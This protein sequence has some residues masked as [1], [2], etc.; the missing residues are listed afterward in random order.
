[1]TQ[2]VL[3]LGASGKI[4]H[5]AIHAFKTAGWDVRTYDRAAGNMTQQAKG[6]DVIINGLNPPAYQNWKTEIPR[7]TRDV[8]AAAKASNATVIIPGNIYNFGAC[9]GTLDETTKQIP[10]TYL[11]LIRV[12]MEKEFRASKVQTIIL[13][14][15][16]FIDP[17]DDIDDV[18]GMIFAA[19]IS[20]YKIT[21]IGDPNAKQAF[22]YLP[23]WARAAVMLAQ[24]RRALGIFE[25][26]PFGGCDFSFNELKSELEATLDRPLKT[27][28]FPWMMLK[29]L[30]PFWQLARGVTAMRYTWSMPHQLSSRKLSQILPD[31]IATDQRL[32][33]RSALPSNIRP[34][35]GVT[36]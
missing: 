33:M 34:D 14:A 9:G 29:M 20:K 15:G 21:S 10:N 3:I 31:F 25:D 12:E 5:N 36:K 27:V 4:G 6:V 13:R 23:D 16:N 18:M 11:G 19:K 28:G 35:N 22:C 26:I 24:K 2:T 17:R 7:I 30:A 32:V 8:I 1:M